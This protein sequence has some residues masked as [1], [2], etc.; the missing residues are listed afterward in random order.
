MAGERETEK[1]KTKQNRGEGM[2]FKEK[3]NFNDIWRMKRVCE[4]VWRGK[5]NK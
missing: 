4:P 5:E 1:N 3:K 2:I